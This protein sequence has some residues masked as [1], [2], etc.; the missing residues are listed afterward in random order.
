MDN[1]Y[2]VYCINLRRRH[3]RLTQFLAAFPKPWFP[4]LKL[5]GAIDGNEKWGCSFSHEAVWQDLVANEYKYAIV[6]EDDALYNG[7]TTDALDTFVTAFIQSNATICL[8]GPENHPKN[9]L[10]EPHN[11][12]DIV[13]PS[14]CQVTTNLGSMSY[15]LTLQGAKDLLAIMDTRGHYQTVDQVITDY[16]KQRNT[17]ICSAPPLFKVILRPLLQRC[18]YLSFFTN[19]L[20]KTVIKI[21]QMMYCSSIL[22]LWRLMKLYPKHI[23]QIATNIKL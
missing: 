17:W 7:P 19:T 3:D 14:I 21:Y 20:L 15:I 2:P 18:K 6:L 23:Q 11:F 13:A 9:K 1:I 4:K 8:L 16:M 5:H 22:R 10:S 12:T